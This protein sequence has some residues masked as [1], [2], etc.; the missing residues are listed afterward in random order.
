MNGQLALKCVWIWF[1]WIFVG[2]LLTD[3]VDKSRALLISKGDCDFVSRGNGKIKMLL[4]WT[5][6]F[7]LA[8]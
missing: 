8:N 7:Q 1:F 6:T 2:E 3:A 4:P 5:W